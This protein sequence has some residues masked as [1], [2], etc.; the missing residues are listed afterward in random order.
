MN[1]SQNGI[2]LSKEFEDGVKLGSLNAKDM[3]VKLNL[4]FT[5]RILSSEPL[6]FDKEQMTKWWDEGF[7]Y[8]KSSS[9][10]MYLVKK[11]GIENVRLG[12]VNG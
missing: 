8:G 10:I 9:K 4:Y 1:L 12:R 6:V 11:S 3:D 2:N 5:P 7:D